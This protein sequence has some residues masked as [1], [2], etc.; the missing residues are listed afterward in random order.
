MFVKY[1]TD[2]GQAIIELKSVAIHQG[3]HNSQFSLYANYDETIRSLVNDAITRF[4]ALMLAPDEFEANLYFRNRK[5][6]GYTDVFPI[7]SADPVDTDKQYTCSIATF[8]TEDDANDAVNALFEALARGDKVFDMSKY[9]VEVDEK[10]EENSQ[11]KEEV[12]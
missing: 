11:D 5:H 10:R 2:Y 9:E 4:V 6:D 3:Y 8:D 7:D 12:S 1:T